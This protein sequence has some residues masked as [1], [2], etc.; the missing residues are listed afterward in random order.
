MSGTDVIVIGGGIV[1]ASAAYH[2]ARS[3]AAITLV[4]RA[5]QGQATAAGAGIISP[6]TSLR[7]PATWFPLAFRAV[8]YYADLLDQL[9]EDGEPTTGYEVVGMLTVAASPEEAARLPELL[10]LI[11]ERKSAGAPNIGDAAVVED[12]Q[13]RSLFPALAPTYGAIHTS[14]AARVDG[15]LLRDA[16]T[17]AAGRRGARIIHGSAEITV[18]GSRATAVRVE[19][20]ELPASAVLLAGGAWSSAI[21]DQLGLLVPVHPQRGQIL[22]LELPQTDTTRW[23]IVVGLHSHYLL[24]FPTSRVV[25]GATREDTAG[26]DYRMT[27]GGVHEALSEALRVAPGLAPATLREIRIGLRP[28]SPDGLPV[29]GRVPG[30][31]NVYLATG[32]GATG[33]QLGPYSGA[34][35]ASLALGAP[36]DLDLAPYSPDRFL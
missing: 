16:L 28:A 3:G 22:H 4:D 10:Q 11:D 27:A 8:S 29:L 2:L 33:L 23:P 13:A 12:A 30:L 25:A 31:E 6:A 26:F 15:R 18:D 21:A 34:A 9:A 24:T 32:H 14:G 1:G 20:D 36:P 5:D 19:G 7:A 17:R 35:V